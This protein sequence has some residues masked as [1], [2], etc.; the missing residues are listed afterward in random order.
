MVGVFEMGVW[1]VQPRFGVWTRM[2]Y[3]SNVE[4]LAAGDS[5][6]TL[7]VLPLTVCIIPSCPYTPRMNECTFAIY[8]QTPLIPS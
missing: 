4:L 5:G 6:F 1:K 2:V 7:L 8:N 3:A